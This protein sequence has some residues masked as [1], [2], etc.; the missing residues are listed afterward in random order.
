MKVFATYRT[1]P[2]SPL[3]C[4]MHQWCERMDALEQPPQ[5]REGKQSDSRCGAWHGK[6]SRS[7]PCSAGEGWGGG[8]SPLSLCSTRGI[9]GRHG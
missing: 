4:R 7:L 5:A 6:T 9:A 1:P 2:P 8:I 3:P